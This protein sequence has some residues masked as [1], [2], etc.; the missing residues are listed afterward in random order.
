[1]DALCAVLEAWRGLLQSAGSG[2]PVSL[3]ALAQPPLR[4]MAAV[5]AA[6]GLGWGQEEASQA[7]VSL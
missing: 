6:S 3:A 7:R 4:W 2:A 5:K 1:M